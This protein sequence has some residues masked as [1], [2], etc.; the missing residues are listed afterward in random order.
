[1]TDTRKTNTGR[2]L[3]REFT[4]AEV[5]ERQEVRIKLLEGQID[6]LKK[7]EMTERRL[8]NAREKV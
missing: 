6:L 1:M 7:F 8:L 3:K 5:I 2:P 4:P